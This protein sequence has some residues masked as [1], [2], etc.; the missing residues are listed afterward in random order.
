M[1]A[2][3][4]SSRPVARYSFTCDRCD[5]E[6]GLV[7]LY[8]DESAGEIIRDSFTGRLTYRVGA[9]NFERVRAVVLAGDVQALHAFDLEVASFYCPPCRACYCG[10][11]WVHWDV[12]DDD[13]GFFWHDSIR[14][15]CPLGHERMLED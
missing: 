10:D 11:H 4:T 15:R 2:E 14:G 5:Q 7:K 1:S 6:A 3:D 12:F 8:G 13:D 9:E